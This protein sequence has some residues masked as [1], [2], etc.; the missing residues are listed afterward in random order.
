MMIEIKTL[1]ILSLLQQTFAQTTTCGGRLT[2]SNGEISTPN[3]PSKYK[4]DLTCQW[5]IEA[6]EGKIIQLTFHDF[7]VE[8]FD[9]DCD[10]DTVQVLD[11]VDK[12]SP[13]LGGVL[14]G[15]KIPE[16]AT[17]SGRFMKISFI[18]DYGSNGGRGFRATYE[19]KSSTE[20]GAQCI[21][22]LCGGIIENSQF[23]TIQSPGYPQGYDGN[24][25]CT[26]TVRG[27]S[28][29][30]RI[31][32]QFLELAFEFVSS[33][34]AKNNVTI[35]DGSNMD[36]NKIYESACDLEDN[37]LVKRKLLST[38][39]V[40]V[41]NMRTSYATD[42]KRGFRAFFEI[43]SNSPLPSTTNAPPVKTDSSSKT[44]TTTTT[45]STKTTTTTSTFN[46]KSSTRLSSKIVST[47]VGVV[48]NNE[49]EDNEKDGDSST[50][51]GNDTISQNPG[52]LSGVVIGAI[53][54]LGVIVLGVLLI[55]AYVHWK[56]QNRRFNI[57]L[58]DEDAQS[59][60]NTLISSVDSQE[61]LKKQKNR[62]VRTPES[63][64]MF[65]L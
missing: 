23:C 6:P 43:K 36:A 7:D 26:W 17:S 33:R 58:R 39:S 56:R 42:E 2:A 14:C 50:T 10:L 52:I 28:E 41:I 27:S 44:T 55:V 61:S 60:I 31:S 57:R 35:Y 53:V 59:D 62:I 47:A 19:F 25:N 13:V 4:Y 9:G 37:R 15:Q 34:C 40:I 20:G 22:N 51:A 45:T 32:F 24:L 64:L 48:D 11:G 49:N 46:T 38:G 54:V 1:L 16:V 18:S 30:D 29:D 65:Q 12:N 5:V 21:E 3:Y 63:E 8:D